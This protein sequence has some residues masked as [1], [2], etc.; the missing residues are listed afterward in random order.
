[1]VDDAAT[2]KRWRPRSMG[3]A[4]PILKRSSHITVRVSDGLDQTSATE[5]E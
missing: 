1:Y 2:M 5:E 4:N 3:R